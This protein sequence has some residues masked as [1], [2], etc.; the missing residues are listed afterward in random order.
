MRRMLIFLLL[1]SFFS[2]DKY[3]R[4]D[5]SFERMDYEG[6]EIQINGYYY[7][8]FDS[9]SFESFFLYRNG[10]IFGPHIIQAST[11]QELE[12][13]LFD[14]AENGGEMLPFNWGIYL[15]SDYDITIER[16]GQTQAG[17]YPVIRMEGLI[18]EDNRLDFSAINEG[19]FEFQEFSPKRDSTNQWIE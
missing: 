7:R 14:D 8:A 13:I 9:E 19:V 18:E 4:E 12:E 5:F 6:D 2:C 11:K 16:W 3:A 10:V 15:I 1:F 17:P